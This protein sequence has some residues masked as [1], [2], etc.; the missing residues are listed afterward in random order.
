MQW[1]PLVCTL[2]E[3]GK[4]S[5]GWDAPGQEM[6]LTH[7]RRCKRVGEGGERKRETRIGSVVAVGGTREEDESSEIRKT[8]LTAASTTTLF[9]SSLSHF[10]FLHLTPFF[11]LVLIIISNFQ[12]HK[13]QMLISIIILPPIFKTESLLIVSSVYFQI[14][15][16]NGNYCHLLEPF[17]TVVITICFNLLLFVLS[18]LS[19]MIIIKHTDKNLTQTLQKRLN[20]VVLVQN[21]TA[22]D[23]NIFLS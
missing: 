9:L 3:C 7:T 5:L 23:S 17:I 10:W 15:F 19:L 8:G 1:V 21:T 14:L 4:W 18:L 2:K 12:S 16:N 13:N 22:V 20:D 6:H 11:F